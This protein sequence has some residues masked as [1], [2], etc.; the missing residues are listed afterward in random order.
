MAQTGPLGC[1]QQVGPSH[2][3]VK[4]FGYVLGITH[5]SGLM[6]YKAPLFS[7]PLAK[8]QKRPPSPLS[9]EVA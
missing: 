7:P 2:V 4:P 8:P 1:G 3:P 6:I 5:V 9:R